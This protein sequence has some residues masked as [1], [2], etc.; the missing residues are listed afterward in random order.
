METLSIFEEAKIVLKKNNYL[1]AARLFEEAIISDGLSLA[2]QIFAWEKI[3]QIYQNLNKNFSLQSQLKMAATYKDAKE[4][5]KG[6]VLLYELFEQTREAYFLKEAYDCCIE[7]GNIKESRVI[8]N[9]Y[10]KILI[11]EKRPNDIYSFLKTNEERLNQSELMLWRIEAHLMEGNREEVV[12]EYKA[13]DENDHRGI[14]ILQELIRYAERKTHFWQSHKE[15]LDI[16][17]TKMSTDG[18]ILILSKK[19]TAKLILNIWMEK[20]ID[21]ELL[22]KTMKVCDR[23]QLN[24]IGRAIASYLEDYKLADT[25]EKRIPQDLLLEDIDLARDLFDSDETSDEVI[26]VRN[27]D[28]LKTMGRNEEVERELEKLKKINPE[29]PYVS[30]NKGNVESRN[31]EEIF[32][33]LLAEVSTY[34]KNNKEKIEIDAYRSMANYYDKEYVQ[35]N[36]ED[37]IIGLNLLNLP[38]VALQL[39]EMVDS[40]AL[41]EE[42]NINLEYLKL[43]TLM[44]LEEYFKVRDIVEDMLGK[45][46][47]KGDELYSL[48][49]LRAEAYLN[50]G[51]YENAYNSF[52]EIKALKSSYRLVNQRLKELEKYK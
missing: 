27:I 33:N 39:S 31:P 32:K 40:E 52:N 49:Y 47:V 25:F 19:Q 44:I 20:V 18:A 35:N 2:D 17:L 15:L 37:M 46:P 4:S 43:E 21:Q 8:A 42:D 50:L 3:R 13:L 28:F 12:R 22:L 5:S 11:N 41:N 14:F 10:L 9:K 23:Y 7:S 36:Y 6:K 30:N 1:E 38:A 51:Q 34:S 45:Y 24:F 48:L 29:H 26:L 16:L